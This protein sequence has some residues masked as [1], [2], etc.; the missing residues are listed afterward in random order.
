LLDDDPRVSTSNPSCVDSNE[1]TA[2]SSARCYRTVVGGDFAFDANTRLEEY[3]TLTEIMEDLGLYDA[4]ALYDAVEPWDGECSQD[5]FR[6]SGITF[7][8]DQDLTRPERRD[9]V[10][11]DAAIRYCRPHNSFRESKG[12]KG[13]FKRGVCSDHCPVRACLYAA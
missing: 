5:S 13:V 12:R 9:L 8:H 6:R 7:F 11:T 10:F 2:S 4:A 3:Q 1:D